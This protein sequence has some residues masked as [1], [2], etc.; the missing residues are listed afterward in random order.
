[1]VLGDASDEEEPE[2]LF[3]DSG[4][5]S[6]TNNRESRKER[7]ERLRKMMEDEDDGTLIGFNFHCHYNPMRTNS[8]E[9]KMRRCQTF[10][11]LPQRKTRPSTSRHPSRNSSKR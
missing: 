7:E 8:Y 4:K 1:V 10:Q 9:M 2:E 5:A 11:N 6:T 3:P